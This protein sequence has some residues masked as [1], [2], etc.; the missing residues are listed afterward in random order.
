MWE[1]AWWR[2]ML[3]SSFHQVNVRATKATKQSLPLCCPVLCTG[4]RGHLLPGEQCKPPL[5]KDCEN[6]W[7]ISSQFEVWTALAVLV[8]QFPSSRESPAGIPQLRD[9]FA[10]KCFNKAR[11]KCK[12]FRCRW[13]SLQNCRCAALT[14]LTLLSCEVW[15]LGEH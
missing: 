6:P 4:M 3:R 1:V 9:G 15:S 7:F 11:K 12:K 2:M 8:E 5:E 10:V 13:Y 14:E